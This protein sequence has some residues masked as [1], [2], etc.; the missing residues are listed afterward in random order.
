MPEDEKIDFTIISDYNQ[1]KSILLG[2]TNPANAFVRCQAQV[3]PLREVYRR[4]R[5]TDECI[6]E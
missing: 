3:I 6:F 2:E 4:P 1:A 5:F